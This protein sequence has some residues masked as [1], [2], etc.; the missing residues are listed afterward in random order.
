MGAVALG[1]RFRGG[2]GTTMDR[3]SS[4]FSVSL[5]ARIREQNDL[6]LTK[7]EELTVRVSSVE[8]ELAGV[9][10]EMAAISQRLDNVDRRVDSI[11]R[12]RLRSEE[13]D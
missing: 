3:N 9:K 6:I 12:M 7:L 2:G 8:R 1:P 10:V 5:L 13:E 11:W 4:S